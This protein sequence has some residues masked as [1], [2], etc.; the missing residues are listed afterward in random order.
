[1]LNDERTRDALLKHL[2]NLGIHAVFHYVPLHSSPMGRRVGKT[3]QPLTVTE[4]VSRQL[5]RLP[6]FADLSIE[7]QARVT[8]GVRAF[9]DLRD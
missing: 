1:M 7:E 5:L 3:P 8:D 4:T 6:L 2:R 9:F